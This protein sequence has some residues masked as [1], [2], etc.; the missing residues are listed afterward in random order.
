MARERE[1]RET[2]TRHLHRNRKEQSAASIFYT[3]GRK[4]A[5]ARWWSSVC[6]CVR[7][8]YEPHVFHHK[9]AFLGNASTKPLNLTRVGAPTPA[10]VS[11]SP[12]LRVQMLSAWNSPSWQAKACS[13]HVQV[14]QNS[15]TCCSEIFVLWRPPM[16]LPRLMLKTKTK[17]K[18]IHDSK[19]KLFKVWHNSQA[20]QTVGD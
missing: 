17:K 10:A 9:S 18:N 1:Q 3:S 20:V 15:T 16:F 5:K 14:S 13:S 2:V 8:Q 12:L 7:Y 11:T 4:E 6:E 19:C